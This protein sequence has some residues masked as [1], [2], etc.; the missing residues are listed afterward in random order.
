MTQPVHHD[1]TGLDHPRQFGQASS[2]QHRA[3]GCQVAD[4][5]EQR[6]LGHVV[7][8][9][10]QPL[11][12]EHRL[13][14]FAAL[15]D[16]GKAH[17]RTGHPQAVSQGGQQ[18]HRVLPG[19]GLQ[20]GDAIT[21]VPPDPAIQAGQRG[22]RGFP[23]AA[24]ARHRDQPVPG[25]QRIHDFGQQFRALYQPVRQAELCSQ[26]TLK[27]QGLTLPAHPHPPTTAHLYLVV[28]LVS[29]VDDSLAIIEATPTAS[30]R[31][32]RGSWGQ[33]SICIG[34]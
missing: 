3:R 6:T 11:A 33:V 12:Q 20:P 34:R 7:H 1:L 10:Q 23:R 17:R 30:H 18:F 28:M 2:E 21:I 8:R 19:T 9:D 16:R 5:I 22:Q 32:G 4:G 14:Q 15:L 31:A 29:L 13:E 26:E 24:G 27:L 25:A